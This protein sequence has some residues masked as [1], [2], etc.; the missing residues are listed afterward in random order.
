MGNQD[1][2]PVAQSPK[3][4]LPDVWAQNGRCPACGVQ[5]LKVTHLPDYADYLACTRCDISFE[6]ENGGRSIRV[7]Y[8]PDQYESADAVLHNR[9]VEASK[10]SA[11]LNERRSPVQEKKADIQPTQII[12]DE[13]A[14][15]R[16]LGMYRLGNKPR[17]IH[18]TLM[19]SGV[20]QEQAEFVL[21]RLKKIAEQDS[22]R[23]NKKF[24]V[25]AGISIFL[26][27]ILAGSWLYASGNLPIILGITTVT[28]APLPNQSSALNKLLKL[29]PDSAKPALMTLP[30]TIVDTRQ[31]PG[32]AL[33]P[34]T[35]KSAARLFGGSSSLWKRDT[36]F[37]SWQMISAGDSYTVVVPTGMVAGYVDNKTFQL[38]SIH[39]PATIYNVNFVTIMCD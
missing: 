13:E 18:L 27:V 39:G 12:S 5:S 22:Q 10:L 6:V 33:C 19:Q 35:A 30:D 25:M 3:W 24:L 7:K 9:W 2:K 1:N 36:Q 20:T 8:L 37:S 21:T 23:Q 28:P 34:A 11:I 15:S 32:R 26:I 16:A 31:G 38:M 4:E 14:W 29:V 17:M